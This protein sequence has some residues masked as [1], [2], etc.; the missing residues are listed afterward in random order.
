RTKR[1]K[2]IGEARAEARALV[3]RARSTT[4]GLI[5]ELRRLHA[6]GGGREAVEKA[7]E[8]RREL[9]QLR[10]EIE[11]EFEVEEAPVLPAAE[12][13]VGKT[14]YVQSLRQKGEIL[15]LS[16]DEALVQVGTMRVQLPQSEL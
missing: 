4:E 15:S 6:A 2:I 11:S 7:E 3:R 16:G 14:V 10:R 8:L 1:E 13:A 9:H 12:L 5:R